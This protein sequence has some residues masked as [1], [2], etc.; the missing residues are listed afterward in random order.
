MIKRI[1]VGRYEFL[2]IWSSAIEDIKI[3]STAKA[4]VFNMLWRWNFKW[5]NQPNK[6]RHIIIDS[7][8]MSFCSICDQRKWCFSST[9]LVRPNF[10]NWTIHPIL[11]LQL[12]GHSLRVDIR[13][14]HCW[15]DSLYTID[16]LNRQF[17]KRSCPRFSG[18][19][20]LP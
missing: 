13:Y 11:F 9:H 20:K 14:S 18:I 12:S 5:E 4:F 3:F 1:V 17:H 6:L 2:Y 15:F 8:I 19:P 16:T 7:S 10:P